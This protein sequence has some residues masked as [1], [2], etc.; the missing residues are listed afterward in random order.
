[1]SETSAVVELSLHEWEQVLKIIKYK[2]MTSLH[3]TDR[4]STLQ[5]YCSIDRKVHA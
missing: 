5:L 3:P 2:A 4:R 1:M